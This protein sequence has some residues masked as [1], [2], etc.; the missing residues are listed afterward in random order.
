MNYEADNEKSEK[1][2]EVILFQRSFNADADGGIVNRVG[3]QLPRKALS[4]TRSRLFRGSC[5][6]KEAKKEKDEK[7]AP[8]Y[9]QAVPLKAT[10]VHVSA[11]LISLGMLSVELDHDTIGQTHAKQLLC[12]VMT[13]L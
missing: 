5:A 4:A 13:N 3:T 10:P 6:K 2:D 12:T 8:H 11:D 7:P 9:L 1:E